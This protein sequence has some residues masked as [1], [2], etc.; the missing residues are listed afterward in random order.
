MRRLTLRY[1]FVELYALIRCY[2]LYVSTWDNNLYGILRYDRAILRGANIFDQKKVPAMLNIFL[3]ENARHLT[4]KNA[5][6]FTHK[7][8]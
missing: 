8:G 1:Q 2:I 7:N 3:K 6:L 5:E 4:L